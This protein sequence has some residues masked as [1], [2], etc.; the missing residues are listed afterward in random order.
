[1]S[2]QPENPSHQVDRLVGAYLARRSTNMDAQVGLAR[3][4]RAMNESA[5]A[6][7][8]P[9]RRFKRIGLTAGVAAALTLAF[10]GGW[11]MGPKQ[12]SAMDLVQEVKRVHNL[13]L[14]RCYVVE[15][16]RVAHDDGRTPIEMARGQVRVWTRGDRFWVEMHQPGNEPPLIWG[17]AE[18]GALWAVL[19]LHRGVRIAALDAPRRL[20][21]LADVYSLNVDTLLDDVLHDCTLTEDS[22][23]SSSKLTRVMQARP[24]TL[25]TR[26]WLEQAT[27]EIDTEARVLR[28]LIIERNRLG[29]PFARVTFSLV[30]T[31]PANDAGYLLEG[32]LTQPFHIYEGNIEP[33]VKLEVLGRWLEARSAGPEQVALASQQE[34]RPPA[35][36]VDVR[37]VQFKD[38]D[39]NVHTPLAPAQK[40]ASLLLFLLPDCPVCNAYAPEIRRVCKEYEAKGVGVFVVHAD[41][42]VTALD[43]RK[44]AKDYQLP[45]SILLDPLHLLVKWT[46]ATM[47][48]EAAVVGPEGKV[49]YLGR[50]DDLFADYGKRRVE[51]NERDLRNALDAVLS[52]KTVPGPT[53]KPIGC[54]L[55]ALRK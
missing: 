27:L 34:N 41:S 37:T 16:E 24:R 4:K 31:R 53:G 28:R 54:H 9:A 51:P 1:M 30:E 40:K 35:S 2:E 17:R 52:N 50:I 7:R 10:L 47:A 46:G 15:F 25:K 26:V 21:L 20:A 49:V 32:R 23:D 8:A 44:H 19:D 3:I 55:P 11:R 14:E 42:D 22:P 12:A 6:R 39:G 13:P 5:P 48:P 29:L 36:N 18:D 45:C 43:A 33:R 38:I